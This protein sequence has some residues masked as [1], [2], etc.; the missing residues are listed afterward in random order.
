VLGG[1]GDAW[2]DDLDIRTIKGIATK[3]K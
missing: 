3:I 1:E 2:F